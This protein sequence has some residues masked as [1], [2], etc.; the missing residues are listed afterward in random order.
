MSK[1]V[2]FSQLDDELTDRFNKRVPSLDHY[3]HMFDIAEVKC[4]SK[5]NILGSSIVKDYYR[6]D[7]PLDPS[8][9]QTISYWKLATEDNLNRIEKKITELKETGQLEKW[10][11][12]HDHTESKGFLTFLICKLP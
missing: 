2:W 12:E 10:V 11:K 1:S 8:W 9:R 3:Q 6:L 5:L 7:G 4:V